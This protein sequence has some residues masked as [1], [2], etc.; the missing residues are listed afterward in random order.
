MSRKH[1]IVYKKNIKILYTNKKNVYK[2]PTNPFV[3]GINFSL[4]QSIQSKII[5]EGK[6]KI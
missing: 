4:W 6:T 3:A 2:D 1:Y 5:D